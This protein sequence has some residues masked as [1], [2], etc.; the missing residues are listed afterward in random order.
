MKDETVIRAIRLAEFESELE[1]HGVNVDD[2]TSADVARLRDEFETNQGA[3]WKVFE[4][5][6]IA[7][8]SFARSR[9]SE[10]E[11]IPS[12][13]G[14]DKATPGQISLAIP[15]KQFDAAELRAWAENELFIT[16]DDPNGGEVHVARGILAV[17]AEH[18]AT[19]DRLA[20]TEAAVASYFRA[21]EFA[22]AGRDYPELVGDAQTAEHDLL[23]LV[24]ITGQGL[25]EEGSARSLMS[26][27][28]TQ[29]RRS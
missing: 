7:S 28:G 17:L 8:E 3:E 11:P 22:Q 20:R 29:E 23:D 16:G 5:V 13:N 6:A 27:G 9:N 18:A 1:Q 21:R 25:P 10:R 14:E 24:G 15:L 12:A 4:S 2:L 26:P 19:A